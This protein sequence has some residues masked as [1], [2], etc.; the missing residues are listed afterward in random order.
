MDSDVLANLTAVVDGDVWEDA[1]A[2]ANRHILADVGKRSD[3]DV[4]ANLSGLR[5]ESQRVDTRLLRH[6]R[7]VQLQQLGD[8]LVGI[9]D[10]DEGAC[11]GL[12]QFNVLVDEHYA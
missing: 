11:Y 9:L 4:L 2:V 6:H 8:A 12:C 10:A 3:I 5:N 7:G 1:C